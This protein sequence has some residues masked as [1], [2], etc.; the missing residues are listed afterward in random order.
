MRLL[1]S[2]DIYLKQFEGSNI[3]KY[4]ILSHT[5]GDDEPTFEDVK[6]D[7]AQGKAGFDKILGACQQA[8]REGYDW[9]W[10]DTC[11]IYKS[12]SAELQESINSMYRWYASA[13]I[14]YVYM[15]DVLTPEAGWGPE[16]EKSRWWSRGWTLRTLALLKIYSAAI[17]LF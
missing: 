5:W 16:F 2:K 3:P 4:A 6:N 15:V 10:I 8:V 17:F 13:E 9:I 1:H 14:C 7:E 12:S 11:C